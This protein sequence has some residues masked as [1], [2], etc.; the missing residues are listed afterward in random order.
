[1]A[2]FH[3]NVQALI[4][5]DFVCVCVWGGREGR[6]EREIE[7]GKKFLSNY[8]REARKIIELHLGTFFYHISKKI[9][10]LT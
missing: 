2:I 4:V 3:R 5:N 9:K 1:L 8:F 6:E 10:I 7:S